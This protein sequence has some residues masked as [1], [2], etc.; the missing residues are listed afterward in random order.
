[1]HSTD[2]GPR[3]PH[4]ITTRTRR[5]FETVTCG[6]FSASH[7]TDALHRLCR[8]MVAAGLTGPAEVRGD[9][10]RLRL[11]IRAVERAACSTLAET[12]ARGLHLRPY[13]RW[14]GPRARDVATKDGVSVSAGP[15]PPASA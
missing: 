6:N 4:Q 8:A 14:S 15:S 12:D 11:A 7:H 10:G 13:R 2:N 1:M 9:D 3:P 5:L